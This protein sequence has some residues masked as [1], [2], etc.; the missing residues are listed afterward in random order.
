MTFICMEE[1]EVNVNITALKFSL[2]PVALANSLHLQP[3]AIQ[4]QECQVAAS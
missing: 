3:F 2:L 1:R 4:K